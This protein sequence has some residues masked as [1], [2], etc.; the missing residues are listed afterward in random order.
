[1]TTWNNNMIRSIEPQYPLPCKKSGGFVL[2]MM[3]RTSSG[4]TTLAKRLLEILQSRDIPAIHYDG[5]EIRDFFGSNLGFE[6]KDRLRVIKTL[7]HLSNKA[8]DAGLS[9]IV[10]A[11]TAN[12]DAQVYV[13]NNVH[14]LITAY[15]DCPIKECMKRDPKGLYKKAK[16][17]E[18][19]T[20][21]GYNTEYHEP[22]FA[23]LI[24]NSGKD[25]IEA[26]I[27]KLYIDINKY[28]V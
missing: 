27:E 24:I 26:C 6:P 5:D 21:A 28:M 15:L 8:Y 10:S 13:K 18:I 19:K 3:G 23:D 12:V 20:L 16:N 7:I 14:H 2:W 11:L 4:K 17:G 9:V 25:S 1:M 22:D